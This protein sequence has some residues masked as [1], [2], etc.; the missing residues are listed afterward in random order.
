MIR[1]VAQA[2]TEIKFEDP[3]KFDENRDGQLELSSRG[4]SSGV[5][6][7]RTA[8]C[9]NSGSELFFFRRECEPIMSID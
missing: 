2:P 9:M 7:F 6:Y 1:S 4:L 8:F 5:P 3:I